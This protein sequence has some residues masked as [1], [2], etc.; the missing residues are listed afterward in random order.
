MMI[1]GKK[2]QKAK[3]IATQT[4]VCVDL[5]EVPDEVFAGRMLGDGVAII[6]S[7]NEVKSPVDG[8]I[9][10]VF[11]TLHAYSIKSDDGLE[12]LVHI[13][14]NTVELKGEGFT[15]RVSDGDRVRAG[16]TLCDADIKFIKEKG[17]ELYTPIVIA[18]ASEVK[19]LE[20]LKGQVVAGETAIMEYN[21]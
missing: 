9:V 2:K 8:T 3:I 14:I 21:K 4:G 12:I 18:N 11:D 15:K 19:G 6:P 7:E 5:E 1:F 16:D 17:Y 10:Q 20:M 13:G